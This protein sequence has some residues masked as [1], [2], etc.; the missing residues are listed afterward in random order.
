MVIGNSIKFDC[1]CVYSTIMSLARVLASSFS[2]LVFHIYMG[3]VNS[4]PLSRLLRQ[5]GL[6]QGLFFPPYP[7]GY[8]EIFHFR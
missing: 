1:I 3:R 7:E 5:A 2:E 4:C 6:T 8:F